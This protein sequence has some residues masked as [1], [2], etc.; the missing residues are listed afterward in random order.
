MAESR[1][2]KGF[3]FAFSGVG[4][5]HYLLLCLGSSERSPKI[6]YYYYLFLH[7]IY[8]MLDEK[9]TQVLPELLATVSEASENYLFLLG[10]LIIIIFETTKIELNQDPSFQRKITLN[11]LQIFNISL[12]LCTPI[13]WFK[14][15]NVSRSTSFMKAFC[16]LLT[17]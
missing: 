2:R 15:C 17:H 6:E 11:E 16:R 4:I 7:N 3:K 5:F 12:S 13:C 9:W 14:H 10:P 8:Q 1:N